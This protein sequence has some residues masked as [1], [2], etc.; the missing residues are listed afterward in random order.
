M[1]V[2]LGAVVGCSQNDSLQPTGAGTGSGG[3]TGAV[4]GG[5]A[6]SSADGGGCAGNAGLVCFV[7]P[8]CGDAALPAICAAGQ[9]TCPA[10]TVESSRCTCFGPQC[11]TGGAGG[12]GGAAGV[13][14]RGGVGGSAGSAQGGR[15]GDGGGAGGRGGAAGLGGGSGAGGRGGA[16]GSGGSGVTCGDVT[17][18]AACDARS[19]CHSVFVD[20]R[21]CACAALGCCARFSRCA[22]GDRAFCIAGPIACDQVAP[23]C[24]GPYV[25][26]YTQSCYEGCVRATECVPLPPS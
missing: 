7:G 13:G 1:A 25:V 12:R 23:Y 2:V 11:G 21:G 26:S 19:D 20:P 17:T 10:G 16:G 14:G 3:A 6:G 15:G 8:P 24:E 22:D 18:Q 5:G 4:D 9:W